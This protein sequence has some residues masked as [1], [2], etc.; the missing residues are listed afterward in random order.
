MTFQSSRIVRQTHIPQGVIK[1]MSLSVLVDNTVRWEGAGAARCRI[2]QPPAPETL[3]TIKDLVAAATGFNAERGDQLIVESLPFESSLN[4]EPPRIDGPAPK[5]KKEPA[6]PAWL[7]LFQ[8]NRDLLLPI[9]LGIGVLLFLIRTVM[10]LVTGSGSRPN[11][12]SRLWSCRKGTPFR[13]P[14]WEERRSKSPAR[15]RMPHPRTERGN[16]PGRVQALAQQDLDLAANV[17]KLWL[18]ESDTRTR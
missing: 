11:A 7:D 12:V 4:S 16:L 9:V 1:P 17:V 10:A 8:K 14:S 15:M 6:G 13:V 18:Q 5:P 3:K 2:L